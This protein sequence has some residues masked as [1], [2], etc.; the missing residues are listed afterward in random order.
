METYYPY[1][2]GAAVI[3]A[4]SPVV[5]VDLLAAANPKLA[6]AAHI[7]LR[8]LQSERLSEAERHKE[9]HR[10]IQETSE[11]ARD[12]GF[13]GKLLVATDGMDLMRLSEG[14]VS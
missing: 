9:N 1:L 4:G 13:T 5:V 3:R 7:Y 2:L 12:A 6:I 10:L 14:T 8:H 11:R